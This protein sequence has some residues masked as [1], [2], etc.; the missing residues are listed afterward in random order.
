M[1]DNYY[2]SSQ[3][4]E[5]ASAYRNHKLKNSSKRKD[6]IGNL[7]S[8]GYKHG[9]GIEQINTGGKYVGIYSHN[10]KMV[11]ENYILM[12]MMKFIKVFLVMI[13]LMGLGN[14]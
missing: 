14:I 3:I 4:T 2:F 12:I 7:D 6:Y 5:E 1:N 10:K 11:G 9:F 8:N 13:K